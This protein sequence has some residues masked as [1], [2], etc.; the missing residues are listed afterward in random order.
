MKATAVRPSPGTSSVTTAGEPVTSAPVGKVHL[1][2]KPA[3]FS[4]V[5]VGSAGLKKRRRGPPA[6]I[7]Q[8]VAA[9]ETATRS[10][11]RKATARTS[12]TPQHRHCLLPKNVPGQ[13]KSSAATC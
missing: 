9:A 3:T 4:A 5:I 13:G 7:G 11:A 10:A 6:Y 12:L 1:T 8:S 2:C